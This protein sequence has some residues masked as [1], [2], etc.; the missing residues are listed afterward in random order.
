VILYD[1]IQTLPM[2]SVAGRPIWSLPLASLW[3]SPRLP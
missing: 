1:G 3:L 2:G